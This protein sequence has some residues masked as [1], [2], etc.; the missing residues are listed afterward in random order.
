LIKKKKK[1]SAAYP[2]RW[3]GF[4]CQILHPIYFGRK[5]SG[6]VAGTIVKKRLKISETA[7]TSSRS[8]GSRPSTRPSRPPSSILKVPTASKR[9]AVRDIYSGRKMIPDTTPGAKAGAMVLASPLKP[10]K[11]KPKFRK[12]DPADIYREVGGYLIARISD[13]TLFEEKTVTYIRTHLLIC[14][15]KIGGISL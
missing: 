1:Q 14:L 4:W 7:S 2:G 13:S 12:P 9:A 6:K 5:S 3:E 8:G 11:L 10:K 15:F